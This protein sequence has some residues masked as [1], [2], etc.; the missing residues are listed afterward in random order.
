MARTPE[1][2]FHRYAG[3]RPPDRRRTCP[4]IVAR[5][6]VIATVAVPLAAFVIAGVADAVADSAIAPVAAAAAA[7]AALLESAR[8]NIAV[9]R[10]ILGDA[11]CGNDIGASRRQET[12]DFYSSRLLKCR[13][14]DV[15]PGAAR[16]TQR[17]RLVIAV[18][19]FLPRQ[20][21]VDAL[22]TARNNRFSIAFF[23][24]VVYNPSCLTKSTDSEKIVARFL[25]PYI[26]YV[27]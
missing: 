1:S 19:V 23:S 7:A 4:E 12:H 27:L 10:Y 24:F 5:V 25:S 8:A 20:R 13:P 16:A 22:Q 18:V 11:A 26:S 21:A 17:R 6:A 14:R 9:Q 15:S 3:A 2:D